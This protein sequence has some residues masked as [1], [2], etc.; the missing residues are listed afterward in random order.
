MTTLASVFTLRHDPAW[1]GNG[2]D[3][4]NMVTPISRILQLS[5]AVTV[6]GAFETQAAYCSR[7]QW[8]HKS[9]TNDKECLS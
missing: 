9:H 3:L 1:L 4:A 5:E 2:L 6:A 7:P 8:L